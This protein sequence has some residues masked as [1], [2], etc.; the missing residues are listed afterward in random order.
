MF[1]LHS[2]RKGNPTMESHLIL[3]QI[4]ALRKE[5]S[6]ILRKDA[7]FAPP[8]IDQINSIHSALFGWPI[9]HLT[10]VAEL[11]DSAN[12]VDAT[13]K[14]LSS[15]RF[16]WDVRGSVPLWPHDKW[17]C[18]DAFG[19]KI[20]VNLHDGY[21]SWGVL[22]NDWENDEVQFILDHVGPGEAFLDVGAN[23]GVYT[24]Q[25]ARAVGP[26]GRVYSVEPMPN[27]Y[28][29]LCR[30]ISD[31]NFDDRCTT[32]NVALGARSSRGELNFDRQ[33][34]NPGASFVSETAT[35]SVEVVPLDSLVS[36]IDRPIKAMK[37]DIEGFE[38]N[39]LE[40]ATRF[41]HHH[42]PV[43]LAELYPR[44]LRRAS[45][46]SGA[47]YFDQLRS[48]SYDIHYLDERK[49]GSRMHRDDFIAAEDIVE[50]FNIVCVPE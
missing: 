34:Y 9:D 33:S 16:R 4:D 8:T 3:E 14:I 2:E 44:A 6:S 28:S 26:T 10:P 38:P 7:V 21:V 31:N 35:G 11:L 1:P 25:A 19:L 18:T 13:R 12:I 23:V 37:V 29:M 40:G 22:H 24:L 27:T 30:S 42:R 50:P 47:D 17:V 20:W 48:L 5:I 15:T 45:N 41:F 39:M 49:L 46:R 36:H 43:I 32:F